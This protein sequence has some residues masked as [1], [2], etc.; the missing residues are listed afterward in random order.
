MSIQDFAALAEML[1]SAGVIISLIY[2][3]TQIKQTNTLN[4]S[5]V[6]QGLAERQSEFASNIAL[7]PEM[8][9]LIAKVQYANITR[10]DVPDVERIQ[11]GYMFLTLVHH[12]YLMYQQHK[13][14]IL[15]AAE[16][17]EW[18]GSKTRLIA[19]PYMNSV[20]PTLHTAFPADFS[21]WFETRY[22]LDTPPDDWQDPHI[23]TGQD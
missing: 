4:R 2:L 10:D 15:S 9:A 14:G 18:V 12:I 1:A 23:R 3:A 22:N 17:E 20:W 16:I 19:T 5:A 8:S 6:H 11:I 7:S 13:E 21:R